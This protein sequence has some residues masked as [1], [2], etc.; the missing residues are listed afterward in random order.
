MTFEP[1]KS[2]PS[3]PIVLKDKS[4]ISP[5]PKSIS[6]ASELISENVVLDILNSDEITFKASSEE[7][8]KK[9]EFFILITVL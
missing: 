6:I 1:E 8:F 7:I 2:I 5:F 9:L 3:L 4:L